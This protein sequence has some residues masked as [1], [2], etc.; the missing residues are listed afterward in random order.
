MRKFRLACSVVLLL[1]PSFLLAQNST[2]R[3]IAIDDIYRM[4][5]VGS[6]QVSPDG[7]WVAYTVTTIDKEADKR[8][9]ALWMINWEGTQD[10]RLTFGQQSASSPQWSPDG[11]YLSFLSSDGEKGKTQIWLLDR[12]GGASQQLTK[13]KE[14]INDY[15]WS[16][17][18]KRILLEMSEDYEDTDDMKKDTDAA[19]A[20]LRSCSTAITLNMM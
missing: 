2:K 18:G 7:K 16:P 12:R 14:E 3:P 17:D 13:V 19:K 8:R 20:P 4:E 10:I 9:T 11:K 6:P 15:H 5:R 1:F